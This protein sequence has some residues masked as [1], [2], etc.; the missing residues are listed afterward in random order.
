M[1]RTCLYCGRRA[2]QFFCCMEC[3]ERY[4]RLCSLSPHR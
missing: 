2:P 1:L 3:R 4:L